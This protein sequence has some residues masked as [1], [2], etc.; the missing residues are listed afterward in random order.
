MAAALTLSRLSVGEGL[1]ATTVLFNTSLFV[2]KGGANYS[3]PETD[4]SVG[5]SGS[6][7]SL[8]MS[9]LGRH[10]NDITHSVFY[11]YIKGTVPL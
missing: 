7:D 6:A 8:V 10:G 1:P 9:C 3:S 11:R 2:W 5:P 4:G